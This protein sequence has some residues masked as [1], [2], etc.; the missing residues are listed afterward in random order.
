MTS[1]SPELVFPK[2]FKK[3]LKA[4]PRELQLAIVECCER[5]AAGDRSPG[6]RI[7]KLRSADG[8]WEA[9]V[10]M[11]NRVTFEWGPA[12]TIVMLNHCNHGILKRPR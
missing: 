11:A 12:G 3:D 7:K 6:L 9:S 10:D 1:D 4:K 2:R 8:V 5:L